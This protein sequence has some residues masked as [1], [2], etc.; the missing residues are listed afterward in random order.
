MNP[1]FGAAQIR[2][3]VPVLNAKT[4]QLHDI[5]LNQVPDH[6]EGLEV[7]VLEGL[8]RATLDVI[9]LAGFNYDFNALVEGETNVLAMAFHDLVSPTDSIRDDSY[10]Q[11][12][13]WT[14]PPTGRSDSG[15]SVNPSLVSVDEG[16]DHHPQSG[17]MSKSKDNLYP[18]ESIAD[19]PLPNGATSSQY[20]TGARLALVFAGMLLTYV[21]FF[22]LTVVANILPHIA[23]EFDRLESGAWIATAYFLPQ[24]AFVLLFG[25]LLAVADIKWMYICAISTFQTGSLV[26]G[27]APNLDVLLVGRAI[28]GVGAAGVN[29]AY[30]SLL[31]RISPLEDRALLLALVGAAFGVANLVGPVLGGTL[32]DQV[33]WRLCFYLNLPFGALSAFA[34]IFLV[35]H[36]HSKPNREDWVSIWES[37]A[38]LDYIGTALCLGMVTSI[39]LPLQW[40]GITKAWDDKEVIACF[41]IF[42]L[43][44]AGLA[45]TYYLPLFYQSA[46]MAST[47]GSG[48]DVLIYLMCVVIGATLSG[49]IVTKLGRPLPVL[50]ISPLL[51]ALGF[52]LAFWSLTSSPTSTRDL[53][54][55]QVL[56]GTGIGGGMQTALVSIQAEYHHEPKLTPQSTALFTL[57][58]LTGGT[59]GIAAAD[60]IFGN[61]L[62]I[63][64]ATYAPNLPTEAVLAVRQS[65][66]GI[67]SLQGD[68]QEN[69]IKAFSHA[70]AY[71]F[72]L[73]GV[74]AVL[75]SVSA[76]LT[77]NYDVRKI[78]FPIT[79]V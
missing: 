16:K 79:T 51:A 23:S 56:L 21:T 6:P 77:K 55:F 10:Y 41:I 25:Q 24:P 34:I 22:W 40:G 37:V 74:A 27:A 15:F 36:E 46:Q 18:P 47:T 50:I 59:I 75:A 60:T 61:R 42:F 71:V 65:V 68:D 45:A 33:S 26:S 1:C 14:P 13:H 31:A 43:M 48:A 7:D 38:A 73:G 63:L 30:I 62:S 12:P 29:V 64:I 53:M 8:S 70:L 17:E 58:Q 67:Y 76:C 3:F 52:G 9:G 66:T 11:A 72:I 5:W 57:A 54:G 19:T 78:T 28:T 39:L 32:T 44:L 49:V 35:K 4:S 20:I 69:V 2:E